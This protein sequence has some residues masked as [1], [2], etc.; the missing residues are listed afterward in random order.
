MDCEGRGMAV[1]AAHLAYHPGEEVDRVDLVDHPYQEV[2]GEAGGHLQ[3]QVAVAVE[4]VLQR[5]MVAEAEVA[6]VLVPLPSQALSLLLSCLQSYYQKMV[7]LRLGCDK[8]KQKEGN[9]T[10]E[11]HR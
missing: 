9:S 2:E 7:L 1:E 11:S 5:L 3:L 6:E 8:Y 4:V 10:A